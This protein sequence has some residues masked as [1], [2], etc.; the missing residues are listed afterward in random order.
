MGLLKGLLKISLFS[1]LRKSYRDL[2]PI[3]VNIF[4]KS[5][6]KILRGVGRGSITLRYYPWILCMVTINFP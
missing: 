3:L 6:I 1:F 2:S 4:P 5:I